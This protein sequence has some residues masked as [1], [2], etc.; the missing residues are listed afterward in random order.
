MKQV[1]SL[2]LTL[3]PAA[4]G[5]FLKYMNNDIAIIPDNYGKVIMSIKTPWTLHEMLH[6][7]R[8]CIYIQD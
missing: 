4:T 8:G 7:T 5:D 1:T 3:V 6:Y 2:P